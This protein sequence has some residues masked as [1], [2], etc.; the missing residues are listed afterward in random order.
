MMAPHQAGQEQSAM[1]ALISQVEVQERDGEMFD[2][3]VNLLGE[4]V[5]HHI[6]AEHTGMFPMAK[7][8]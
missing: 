8:P 2:A 5:K 1:E 3:D 4:S 7:M 6:K